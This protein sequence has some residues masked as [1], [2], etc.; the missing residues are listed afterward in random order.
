MADFSKPA[1][2]YDTGH[3]HERTPKSSGKPTAGITNDSKGK[4]GETGAGPANGRN[5]SRIH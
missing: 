1:G 3:D 2:R 5:G 4:L